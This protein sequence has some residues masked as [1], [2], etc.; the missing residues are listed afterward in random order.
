MCYTVCFFHTYRHLLLCLSVKQY[1]SP[2]KVVSEL[3]SVTCHMG[4][5]TQCYLPSNISSV[6]TMQCYVE[7]GYATVCR[8][9]AHLS[10]CP[11]VT[12]RYRDHV[13]SNIISRLISLRFTLGLIPT[14]AIWCN[15]NTSKI[16]VE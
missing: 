4:S 11:S 8:L 3:W 9:S 10:V 16:R 6:F 13:T 5:V 15:G 7:H 14:W 1:S 2:E 12:F